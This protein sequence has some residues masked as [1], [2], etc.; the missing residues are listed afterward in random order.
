MQKDQYSEA[1]PTGIHMW[2][3]TNSF[4]TCIMEQG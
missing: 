4:Q 2:T 3:C 1:S